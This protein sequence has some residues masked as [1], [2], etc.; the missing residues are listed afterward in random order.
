MVEIEN[1]KFQIILTWVETRTKNGWEELIADMLQNTYYRKD[2]K[3]WNE[4]INGRHPFFIKKQL[5]FHPIFIMKSKTLTVIVH[6][7]LWSVQ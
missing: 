1:H 7:E 4:F 6:M 5:M 3:L 2:G